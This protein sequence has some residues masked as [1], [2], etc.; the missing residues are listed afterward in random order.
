MK[1]LRWIHKTLLRRLYVQCFVLTLA[2]FRNCRKP[3]FSVRAHKFCA[4]NKL[5]IHSFFNYGLCCLFLLLVFATK[6][7]GFELTFYFFGLFYLPKARLFLDL[8]IFK[9]EFILE[10]GT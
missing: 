2:S 10:G 6:R 9:E 8:S 5:G 7:T 3:E 1:K 4:D